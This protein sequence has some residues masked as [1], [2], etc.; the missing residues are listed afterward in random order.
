MNEKILVVEDDEEIAEVIK[1]YLGKREYK[2]V[3][4]S[5]G[6]EGMDEFNNDKFDLLMIDIMMPEMNGFTLCKNIRLKSEVPIIIIS[7]KNRDEDKVKGLKL[8]ADDYL[9]KPF[10]LIELEARVESH[11]RRYKRYKQNENK[12]DIWQYRGGLVIYKDRKDIEVDGKK[13]HL[14]SKE[15]SLLILMAQNT[16]RAF[17]KKELYENVWNEEELNSNNTVTVHVKEIRE[18]L[19]ENIKNP[20]YIETVWGTG[21]RFIGERIV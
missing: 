19:K 20:K 16:N 5:T 9:T 17:T 2:V 1:E 7:A 21:Y 15:W 6:K 10:S 12:E 18:K 11:L 4:A 14:T 3:W 8:G 13:L